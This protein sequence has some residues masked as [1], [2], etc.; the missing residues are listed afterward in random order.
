MFAFKP[1]VIDM[2]ELLSE[3]GSACPCGSGQPF[4]ACCGLLHGGASASTAEALMRSRYSA[5]VRHDASY[6]LAT[7]HAS[8]RPK[9]LELNSAPRWLGLD[10]RCCV[11]GGPDDDSGTVEFIARFQDGKRV[12][13]LHETSR[14][15]REA[16]RWYYLDGTLHPSATAK[17]GRNDP[18]PCGSGRKSKHCCG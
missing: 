7:W 8:V 17:V 6:L 3:D 2:N 15:V 18:C 12:D 1:E 10:I 9:T 5:F 4:V 16:G 11:A 13:A 14:F